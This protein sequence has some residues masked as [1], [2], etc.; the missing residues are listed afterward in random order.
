MIIPENLLNSGIYEISFMVAKERSIPLFYAE[1][2]ITIE[3][4]D[5]RD[6]NEKWFGDLSM[7]L[8]RPELKWELLKNI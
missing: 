6:E 4:F 5:E 2:S 7:V 1:K 3:V 8:I